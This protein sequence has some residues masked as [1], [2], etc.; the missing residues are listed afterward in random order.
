MPIRKL[1]SGCAVESPEVAQRS[2]EQAA[3]D[4][5]DTEHRTDAYN[6][7]KSAC[8]HHWVIEPSTGRFSQGRC[9]KC[10]ESRQFDNVIG[11][12]AHEAYRRTVHAQH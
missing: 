10:G 6:G 5:L 8:A 3:S 1:G 12:S 11:L 7:L 9:S 4:P 2:T